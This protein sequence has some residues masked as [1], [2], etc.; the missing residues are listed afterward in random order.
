MNSY[1]TFIDI[2]SLSCPVFEIF[3][4]KVWV[5]MWMY[6]GISVPHFFRKPI[7]D[8]L[9]D[10]Y[11]HF[12]S[13]SNRFWDIR[14][15]SFQGLT[16]TFRGH[17]RSKIFAPFESPYMNSYLTS[18]DTFFLSC[19]V[20]EIFDFKVWVWMWM[21]MYTGISVPH[22]FLP[23]PPPLQIKLGG[24]IAVNCSGI[25]LTSVRQWKWWIR[26]RRRNGGRVRLAVEIF[27]VA[28]TA[29]RTSEF[30]F[31]VQ[32]MNKIIVTGFSRR[33]YHAE[34]MTR[35]WNCFFISIFDL[36]NN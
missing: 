13:I 23:L 7:H 11:W 10:F 12:L 30:V 36:F 2:F 18:F 24:P 4:F 8:F 16:L 29:Q 25:K 1:L 6:T 26:S 14:L 19:P 32:C 9:S 5:W 27:S 33:L 28:N 31:T 34:S 3:D 20:F 21:W 22:F 17:L 15:Q 35:H